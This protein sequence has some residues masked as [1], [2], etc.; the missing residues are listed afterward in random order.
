MQ[1]AALATILMKY[2]VLPDIKKDILRL[3]TRIEPKRLEESGKRIAKTVLGRIPLIY[4]SPFHESLAYNWKI[5]FNE[6]SKTHAF[7]H[8]FPELNHN[9]MSAYEKPRYTSP[10]SKLFFV[11]MLRDE[12]DHTRIQKRMR[13]TA[14][15][16]SGSAKGVEVVNLRGKTVLEKMFKNLVLADWAAY[17]LAFLRKVDP[18]PVRVI[19]T[20]KEQ[21]KKSR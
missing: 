20:F 17:W 21:M 4:S 1:F 16:I 3:E 15:L 18:T 7:M 2:R 12:K 8:V 5:R 11:I 14:R 6:T 10:L 13:L 19:E 9:E